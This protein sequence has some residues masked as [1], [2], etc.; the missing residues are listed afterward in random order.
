MGEYLA[1]TWV[2]KKRGNV[3]EAPL[4]QRTNFFSGRESSTWTG[5]F[6]L[7]RKAFGQASDK[8]TVSPPW[9]KAEECF[10]SKGA[11]TYASSSPAVMLERFLVREMKNGSW[12]KITLRFLTSLLE[13][14]VVFMQSHLTIRKNPPL[15]SCSQ[16]N[17]LNF[18][19]IKHEESLT[20]SWFYVICASSQ[21]FV[22]LIARYIW[23]LFN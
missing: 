3:T 17:N 23:L 7:R 14:K 1:C 10:R 9:P 18:I 4:A 21:S 15:L 8:L 12:S 11:K 13:S 5:W 6:W 16:N 2:L 20:S 22:G 19:S